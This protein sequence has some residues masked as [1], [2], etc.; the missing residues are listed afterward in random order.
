MASIREYELTVHEPSKGTAVIEINPNVGTWSPF[1][2][3]IPADEMKLINPSIMYGPAKTVPAP[4]VIE[5]SRSNLSRDSKWWLLSAA[6]KATPTQS[7]YIFCKKLPST[8]IFG[9]N[10]GKPQYKHIFAKQ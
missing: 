7:Y 5:G 10:G 6:D 1:I 8:I 4:G 2:V 9:V 3:A